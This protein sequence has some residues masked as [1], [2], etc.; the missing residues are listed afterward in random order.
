LNALAPTDRLSGR[1]E[2]APSLETE[3]WNMVYDSEKY[4]Y[5]D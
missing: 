2:A 5:D 3:L 1:D 4:D